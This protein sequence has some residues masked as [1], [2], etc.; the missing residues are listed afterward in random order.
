VPGE[1]QQLGPNWRPQQ[2]TYWKHRGI[3]A[4]GPTATEI[5]L[6]ITNGHDTILKLAARMGLSISATTSHVN[7][8][9][10]LGLVQWSRAARKPIVALVGLATH[11][12]TLDDP[13]DFELTQQA[14]EL[15]AGDDGERNS[16][17]GHGL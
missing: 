7:R 5:L 17:S 6:L 3:V 11:V 12:A 2:F 8:L 13:I 9:K 15:L 14:H 1:S 10:G 4:L 16:I